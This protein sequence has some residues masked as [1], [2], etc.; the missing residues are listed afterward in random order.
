VAYVC[1]AAQLLIGYV[2]FHTVWVHP[3][4]P[5]TKTKQGQGKP[6]FCGPADQADVAVYVVS[7]VMKN[8]SQGIL[9][10]LW[11][12]D[13][14]FTDFR[15]FPDENVTLRNCVCVPYVANRTMQ[16]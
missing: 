16:K 14:K 10:Q 8:D 15:M 3:A 7:Q 11:I 2:Y 12:S 9:G 6:L 4:H 13:R 1:Q 5:M